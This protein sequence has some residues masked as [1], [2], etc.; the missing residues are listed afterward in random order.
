LFAGGAGQGSIFQGGST[1]IR[2][3][4]TCPR[5]RIMIAVSPGD[6]AVT[7]PAAETSAIESSL[8]E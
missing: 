2:A 1:A 5:W 6:F 7:T 8:E 4:A 3:T